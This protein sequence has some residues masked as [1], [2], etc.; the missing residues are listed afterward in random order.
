LSWSGNRD[1]CFC[2][3]AAPVGDLL[4]GYQLTHARDEMLD[5]AGRPR[6]H[7][8]TLYEQ[9]QTLSRHD[10]DERCAA[11]DRV[12]RDCSITFAHSGEEERPFPLDLVPRITSSS[13]RVQIEGVFH[14]PPVATADVRVEIER[15]A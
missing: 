9:I 15:V 13:E 6:H 3:D 11:R 5:T 2:S 7:D 12:F 14:G 4:D 8:A 1:A 10:V